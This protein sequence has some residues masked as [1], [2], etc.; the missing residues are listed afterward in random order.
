[1]CSLKYVLLC[2]LLMLSSIIKDSGV[3]LRSMIYLILKLSNAQENTI[4]QHLGYQTI[5]LNISTVTLD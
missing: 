1:M 4:R 2:V 3:L 5:P